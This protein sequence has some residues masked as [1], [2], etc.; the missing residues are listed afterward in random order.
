METTC[1]LS[2]G[3]AEICQGPVPIGQKKLDWVVNRVSGSDDPVV[4]IAHLKSSIPKRQ[5]NLRLIPFEAQDVGNDIP[6]LLFLK[7]DVRH[8]GM[9][10]RQPSV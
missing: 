4:K 9:R 1:R 2:D 5:P 7:H 6:Q 10:G 3:R 8:G